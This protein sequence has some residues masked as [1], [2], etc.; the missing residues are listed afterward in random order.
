M[1][2]KL[3]PELSEAGA[4]EVQKLIDRFKEQLVKFEEGKRYYFD[5]GVFQKDM[6]READTEWAKEIHGKEVIVVHGCR[7]KVGGYNIF[8]DWCVE[9]N[10]NLAASAPELL[11]ALKSARIIISFEG[12]RPHQGGTTENVY[13]ELLLQIDTA[14][15]KAEGRGEA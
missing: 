3:Y 6:G 9:V 12:A 15:A 5:Y 14:L 13:K 11:E 2:S 10:P 8:A 7:G 1:E 4:E